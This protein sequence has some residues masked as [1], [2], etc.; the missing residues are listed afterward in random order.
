MRPPQPQGSGLEVSSA[1]GLGTRP[2]LSLRG[3][4]WKSPQPPGWVRGLLSASGS[5]FEVSSAS[6]SGYRASSASGSRLLNWMFAFFL[7]SV[8]VNSK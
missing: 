4:D 2:P 5:G 3:L 6:G 7:S 1:S 8:P